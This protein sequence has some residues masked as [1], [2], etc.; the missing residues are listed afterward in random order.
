MS[1]ELL[2]S[3][4]SRKVAKRQRRKEYEN[5]LVAV[6]NCR[7]LTKLRVCPK[8]RGNMDMP[9]RRDWTQPSPQYHS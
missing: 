7:R 3:I 6:K 8:F 5:Y 9:S 4:F 1:L 2:I